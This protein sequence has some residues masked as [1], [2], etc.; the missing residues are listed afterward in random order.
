MTAT[1]RHSGSGN[2]DDIQSIARRLGTYDYRDI[3]RELRRMARERKIANFC[4]PTDREV[5]QI[6]RISRWNTRISAWTTDDRQ[7][8]RY[9]YIG[10]EDIEQ[11]K[12]SDRST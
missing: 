3:T 4:C 9:R 11:P 7:P 10:G 5:R 2:R 6:L 1:R 12:H 8:T